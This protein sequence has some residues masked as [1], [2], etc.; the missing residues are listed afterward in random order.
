MRILHISASHE[1]A[2]N[3][4]F[5][6][7]FKQACL[8]KGMDIRSF[9][10]LRDPIILENIKKNERF[11]EFYIGKKIFSLSRIKD[12]YF[13]E[14]ELIFVENPKFQFNNDVDIPVFYYHRDL[15]SVMYI[16]NPTHLGLR[17]WSVKATT[18]G[19]PK[20]G[21]PEIIELYHPE[22][23]WNEDIKKIW[24]VHAI[25]GNEFGEL[26]K[27][28]NTYRNRKGWAYLGSYKSVDEMMKFNTY[29]YQ[30]YMHHKDII[31]YVEKHN[32]SA[33]FCRVNYSLDT[34]KQHLFKYDATLII[35]AWDSWETRRLYEA[36]YCGCVPILYIQNKNAQR[37]FHKLGYIN[38][39]TC[40][41]FKT[42]EELK[43]LNIY[44]YD[45]EKIRKNGKDMVL[46]RHTYE[47]RVSELMH[48]LDS[49]YVEL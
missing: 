23:W 44:E 1:H 15:K 39:E 28:K 38:K 26:N 35:P 32:I 22:I 18:D 24:F 27:F 46:A 5:S 48:L 42:K 34:Y 8:K 14:A 33:K 43:D 41:T 20:G 6:Y 7:H 21:Q 17:F 2:E 47:K 13:P 31:D 19:R 36:S 10:P 9:S 37:V 3:H 29:H 12:N 16:K 11:Q 4:A 25:S 30:I 40:I 49:N 45:L